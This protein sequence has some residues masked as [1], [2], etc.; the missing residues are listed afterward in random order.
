MINK[1]KIV[2]EAIEEG[3][4]ETQFFKAGITHW[5]LYRVLTK[6]ERNKAKAKHDKKISKMLIP[7]KK[8]MDKNLKE[9]AVRNIFES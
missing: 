5:F 2:L 6:E 4:S 7:L 3:A 8:Q 1:K 9:T